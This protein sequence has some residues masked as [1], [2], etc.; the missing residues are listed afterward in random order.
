MGLFDRLMGQGIPQAQ[1]PQ[2]S[3]RQVTQQDFMQIQSNP[4]SFL[5]QYGGFNVPPDMTTPDQI[6]PYLIQS[7][8][9][10]Q[11]K[12]TQIQQKFGR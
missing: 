8:Q 6:I 7:G 9:V 5:S 2:Q 10:T 11:N 12:I 3:E 1:A 4:A